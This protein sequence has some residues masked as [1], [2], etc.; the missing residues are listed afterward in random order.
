MVRGPNVEPWSH[1]LPVDLG[2]LP[3]QPGA[4]PSH[5]QESIALSGL[6]WEEYQSWLHQHCLDSAVDICI[7]VQWIEHP[8]DVSAAGPSTLPDP[9]APLR[10]DAPDTEPRMFSLAPSPLQPSA[11]VLQERQISGAS[12]ESLAQRERITDTVTCLREDGS[13]M[14]K[15]EVTIRPGTTLWAVSESETAPGATYLN[16]KH[17]P[18]CEILYKTARS[19]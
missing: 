19:S 5:L 9:K 18:E 2:T 12:P 11:S 6:A 10:T 16:E 17:V 14:H 4:L 13:P 8:H 3:V 7:P 1:S 15:M